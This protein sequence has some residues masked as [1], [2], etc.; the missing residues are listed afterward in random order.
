[1][2]YIVVSIKE[3]FQTHCHCHKVYTKGCSHKTLSTATAMAVSTACMTSKSWAIL[4]AN[5]TTINHT[6]TIKQIRFHL[7]CKVNICWPKVV[8]QFVQY[9]QETTQKLCAAGRVSL[10]VSRMLIERSLQVLSCSHDD[11]QYFL[12]IHHIVYN[13]MIWRERRENRQKWS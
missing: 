8:Q 5:T 6:T 12:C 3:W 9:C 1:M 4:Y 7:S 13:T 11:V 2:H 10:F